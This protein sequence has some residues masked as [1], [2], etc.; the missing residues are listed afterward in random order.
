ME[1]SELTIN[2]W[3][4][5]KVDNKEYVSKVAMLNS[6]GNIAL[7]YKD[8]NN[9]IKYFVTNIN[10]IYPIELTSKILELNDWKN[11]QDENRF[12]YI[13]LGKVIDAVN[14]LIGMNTSSEVAVFY[15]VYPKDKKPVCFIESVH[16][17]QHIIRLYDI[18][19]ADNIKMGD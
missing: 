11:Y 15:W 12:Y 8:E 19:E 9:L 4:S 7:H 2:D 3:V 14:I 6:N 17:L 18:E 13:K 5:F 16:H 1:I 10:K